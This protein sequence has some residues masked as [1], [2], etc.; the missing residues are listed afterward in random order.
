MDAPDPDPSLLRGRVAVITGASRG[1]GAGLAAE[2]AARGLRLGLCSRSEPAV[3]AG[4]DALT[5]RVD[6]GDGSAVETFAAQVAERFGRIDLWINNAGVLDPVKP[7][8]ELSA[9]ELEAHLRTNL[10]GVLHGTKAFLRHLAARGAS[11]QDP[12]VLI[13]ISS[14]AAWHGYAGWGAYCAGKAAV[15]RLTETV[16][17]EEAGRGLRAWAV[18][19]GV[20]DTAMQERIRSCDREV[21]PEIDRF[22]ALK[23]AEAFNSIPFIARHLLAIAFDPTAAPAEVVVRLPAERG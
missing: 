12:G 1:I 10:I 13:N 21:F 6:V 19:P 23:E 9:D 3:P 14:G 22:L 20:V 11:E 7:V 8:R 2:F 4:A 15:D 16:Q 18:A 17:L 5:A